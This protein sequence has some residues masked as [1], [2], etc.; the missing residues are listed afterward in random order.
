[1]KIVAVAV[2]AVVVAAVVVAVVT[3]AIAVAAVDAAETSAAVVAVIARHAGK[4]PPGQERLRAARAGDP[5]KQDAPG[6]R[7]FREAGGITFTSIVRRMLN[8]ASVASN[9][10]NLTRPD[11]E[12]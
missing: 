9:N 8:M 3:A 4:R 11:S 12:R 7:D 10:E 5:S 1:M 2:A 6:D